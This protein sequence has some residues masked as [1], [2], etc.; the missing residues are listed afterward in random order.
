M[1]ASAARASICIVLFNTV[2]AMFRGIGDSRTPLI[3]MGVACVSNIAGD[4]LLV[5]ALGMKSDGAALATVL[6][7]GISVAAA[8]LIVRR[9]GLGFAVE[10]SQLRPAWSETR[11]I[12]RYGLPIAAQEL[13]TGVS[14]MVI[15]AILN[16]FGVIASAGVG[17]AEKLCSLMFIVPGAFMAAVS[18][19]SAQNIGAGDVARARS[20]MYIGMA[21]SFAFGLVMFLISFTHG[22]WLAGFFTTDQAVCLAAAD[23]LRSYSVDC[24]IVGFNFC[25]MGY[26]NGHGQTLFVAIQ[27]ILSTFLVRIPV[28]WLMSRVEGVSLFQVGF[29]TPLAT[30][31]AVVITVIYLVRYERKRAGEGR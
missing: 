5:G 3:L 2:S 1:C 14:F 11:A 10:K 29:A 13:L 19:F 12:L 7:Q 8:V 6:A 26:L 25:M 22:A 17:V 23:Y 15:L 30:V 16:G 18:A 28:S 21:G 20:S 24:V 9:R 27:G 31:F 4:L